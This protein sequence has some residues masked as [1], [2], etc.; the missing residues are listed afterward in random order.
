MSVTTL[1]L[2]L[3]HP[4]EVKDGQL[5]H[6]EFDAVLRDGVLVATQVTVKPE[7]DDPL[8]R[9]IALADRVNPGPLSEATDDEIREALADELAARH[10]R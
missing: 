1:T 3:P 6:L 7:A 8:E 4:L 10:P 5:V 2:D 9:M